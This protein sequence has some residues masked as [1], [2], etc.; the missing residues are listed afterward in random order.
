M[1]RPRSS[2][3][4]MMM[5][6]VTAAAA[7]ALGAGL[8]RVWPRGGFW[9]RGD[10]AALIIPAIGVNAVLLARWSRHGAAQALLQVDVACL[11]FLALVHAIESRRGLLVVFW[12]PATFGVVLVAPLLAIEAMRAARAQTPRR[13]RWIKAAEAVMCAAINLLAAGL[14]LYFLL[15]I[16]TVAL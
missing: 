6:V 13:D 9:F 7:A 4:L 5:L 3:A 16:R 14:E 11:A 2:L 10:L 12:F 8:D 15:L 1:P